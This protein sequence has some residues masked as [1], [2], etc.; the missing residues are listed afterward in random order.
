M[1]KSK[2]K[3]I[4]ISIDEDVLEEIDRI[5]FNFKLDRSTY[6]SSVLS[7]YILTVQKLD[8]EKDD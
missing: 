4:H 8:S 7:G 1:I 5:C 2:K 3:K 6:I